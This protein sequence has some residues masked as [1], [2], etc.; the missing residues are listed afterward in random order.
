MKW[1]A[2]VRPPGRSF[3]HAISS[4]GAAIDVDLARRQ[5]ELY[6]EALRAA[7]A[8]VEVFADRVYVGASDR[9]HEAGIEQLRVALAP[10]PVAAIPVQGLL[11]LLSGVT[12]LSLIYSEAV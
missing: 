10:L 8:E 4:T 7:G 2:L 6:C 11:H 9:S 5:H 1:H 3:A 12:C